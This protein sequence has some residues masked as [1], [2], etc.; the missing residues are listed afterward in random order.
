MTDV[1]LIN[2][3]LNNTNLCKLYCLNDQTISKN[4]FQSKIGEE[5]KNS[6]LKFLPFQLLS[7]LSC[8]LNL[9]FNK[10]KISNDHNDQN[11]IKWINNLSYLTRTRTSIIYRANFTDKDLLIIKNIDNMIEYFIG[12]FCCNNLRSI[13][14]NFVYTL[15]ILKCNDLKNKNN[16]SINHFCSTNKGNFIIYE[17]IIGNSLEDEIK[18]SDFNLKSCLSY[19]I[20]IL[21]SLMIAQDKYSFVHNDLHTNNIM[22]R[23]IIGEQIITYFINGITYKLKVSK[24]ATII[25]YGKSQFVYKKNNINGTLFLSGKDLYSF[26]CHLIDNLFF[27]KRNLYNEMKWILE[28]FSFSDKY[29]FYKYKDNESEMKRITTVGVKAGY[30][31]NL[32]DK[33][34]YIDLQK[35]IEFIL[36]N[37][38]FLNNLNN[39]NIIKD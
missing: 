8:N 17:K 19:F 32:K 15:G 35:Y 30:D 23:D 25:D 27:Y 6:N 26:I 21:L 34:C 29:Q 5:K 7:K 2:Y 24:I 33:E 36:T 16:I 10:L 38:N 9:S 28:F 14:P 31:T 18:K 1:S 11:I 20:Q 3:V 22:I 13:I 37:K 12:T 4:D 39:L